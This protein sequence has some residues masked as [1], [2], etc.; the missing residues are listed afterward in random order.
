MRS[1]LAGV[2]VE[3]VAAVAAYLLDHMRGAPGRRRRNA[4]PTGTAA[5]RVRRRRRGGVEQPAVAALEGIVGTRPA[6]RA[7]WRAAGW[8]GGRPPRGSAPPLLALAHR[9]YR[10]RDELVLAEGLQEQQRQRARL[11]R[12]GEEQVAARR[13]LGEAEVERAGL[14][15]IERFGDARR[16][17]GRERGREARLGTAG[18]I[19]HVT[20]EEDHAAWLQAARQEW[21][22]AG[23]ADLRWSVGAAPILERSPLSRLSVRAEAEYTYSHVAPYR[24]PWAR[25]RVLAPDLLP[26][27]PAADPLAALDP[28]QRAAV[29]TASA[30]MARIDAGP[31]LVIAGAGSGKTGTLAHRVARLVAAGADPGASCC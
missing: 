4:R 13:A 9:A 16:R 8:R 27:P 26:R 25:T 18:R 5:R 7:A 1:Q 24:D 10:A 3:D 6:G 23:I 2:D 21:F 15:A 31:L 20:A 22:G 30:P 29:G 11:R 14:Q 19:D 17:R 28:A 12:L